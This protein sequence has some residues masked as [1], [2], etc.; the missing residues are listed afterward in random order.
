MFKERISRTVPFRESQIG[1]NQVTPTPNKSLLSLRPLRF[2]FF[3]VFAVFAVFVIQFSGMVLAQ[4]LP[5]APPILMENFGPEVREHLQKA[6]AEVK[7]RPRDPEANGRMGMTLQTYEEYRVAAVY[8]QRAL[9]LQPDDFRWLYYSAIAQAALGNHQKAAEG[10]KDALRVR[11]EY[12]QAHLRLADSL[13]AGG[14][15]DESHRVYQSLIEKR[16]GFP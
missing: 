10:F 16:S 1:S 12:L 14:Q 6:L 3:A 11:P 7:A 4:T 9:I 2:N 15:L 5:E 8:Y 13:F